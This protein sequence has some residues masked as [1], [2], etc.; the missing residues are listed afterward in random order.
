M[1]CL[2]VPLGMHESVLSVNECVHCLCAMRVYQCAVLLCESYFQ[3]LLCVPSVCVCVRHLSM[4]LVCVRSTCLWRG[5]IHTTS[6]P[7]S[8]NGAASFALLLPLSGFSVFL[9]EKRN[10]AA[11]RFLGN[12]QDGNR[13][14]RAGC[15]VR[16]CSLHPGQNPKQGLPVSPVSP[17]LG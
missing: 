9:G 1:L 13:P 5:L 7:F 12:S 4:S 17:T 2:G 3:E 8:R 11:W 10:K 15:Q 16:P 14:C 6:V